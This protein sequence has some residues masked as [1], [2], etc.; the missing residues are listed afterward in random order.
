MDAKSLLLCTALRH[1]VSEPNIE[2]GFERFQA[3][4]GR[5]VDYRS[6]SDAVIE[7]L[8]EGLIYE[9]IRLPEGALQC[10]WHF[11]LTPNGVEVAR[12][13]LVMTGEGR[14]STSFSSPHKDAMDGRVRPGHDATEGCECPDA[15]TSPPS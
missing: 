12:R 5:P 6:F 4:I 1:V 11:Q 9:P 7:C 3:L 2:A 14:S 10:H 13:L 8:R 15:P